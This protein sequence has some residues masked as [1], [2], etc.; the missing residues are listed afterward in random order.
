MLKARLLGV[1]Q[2]RQA[3]LTARAT[4]PDKTL[5]EL[6]APETM[7]P[8]LRQAHQV[9]DDLIDDAYGYHGEN[10]DTQPR[11]VFVWVAQTIK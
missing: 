6:Y 11:R 2:M 4:F 7:P 9:L 3:I 8:A 10:L 5:A 1:A